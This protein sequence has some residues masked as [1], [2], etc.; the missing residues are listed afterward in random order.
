MPRELES[1]LESIVNEW[2]RSIRVVS[3]H[4]TPM[5]EQWLVIVNCSCETVR[6]TDV[7]RLMVPQWRKINYQRGVQL[8]AR[9]LAS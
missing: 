4:Q 1:P 5:T 8:I 7:I 6:G 2:M 3:G 9:P